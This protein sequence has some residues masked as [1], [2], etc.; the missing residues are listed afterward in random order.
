MYSINVIISPEFSYCYATSIVIV[1][2]NRSFD[3]S[4]AMNDLHYT[5]L[6][7]FEEGWHQTIDW[8]K[9]NWLPRYLSINNLDQKLS[10]SNTCADSNTNELSP[11]NR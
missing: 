5:P 8:F 10:S 7:E 2:I 9:A 11:L 3:I 6:I 4:A 1:V